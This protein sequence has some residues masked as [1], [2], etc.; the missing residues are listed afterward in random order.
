MELR[1]IFM[2]G[3]IVAG[4]EAGFPIPPAGED[5]VWL[6]NYMSDFKKL[7]DGGDADF[8]GVMHELETRKDLK[9]VLAN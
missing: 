2:L 9:D 8:K 3:D 1:G 7:A 4:W 6:K 5:K